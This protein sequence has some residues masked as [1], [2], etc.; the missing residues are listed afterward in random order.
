MFRFKIIKHLL[1]PATLTHMGPIK[2]LFQV[3][4]LNL[5]NL[6]YTR[7]VKGIRGSSKTF[8][9]SIYF[10]EIRGRADKFCLHLNIENERENKF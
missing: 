5:H 3:R 10:L 1:G 2:E 4:D 9:E 7:N 6:N 8:P